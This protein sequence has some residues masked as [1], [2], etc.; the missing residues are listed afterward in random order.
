MVDRD[1]ADSGR[2]ASVRRNRDEAGHVRARVLRPR[3]ERVHVVAVGSDGRELDPAVV[4]LGPEGLGQAP[5]APLHRLPVRV[6]R[7]GHGEGDIS[8]AVALG[9][10]PPADL[11]VAA[12]TAR[13]HEADVSLLEHVGRAVADACLGSRV[14]RAREAECVLIEVRR[15]LRVPDPDLEVIPAVDRHEVVVAHEPDSSATAKR[16]ERRARGGARRGCPARSGR[17]PLSGSASASRRG[18]GRRGWLR[19][20]EGGS[21]RSPHGTGR[22]V[23]SP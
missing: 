19:R 2:R 3:D 15:L 6:R 8:D 13:Q 22:R 16:P 4:V 18:R 10:R 7:V 9:G 23:L 11:A 12:K 17:H 20:R 5:C 1:Q 14:A 21:R